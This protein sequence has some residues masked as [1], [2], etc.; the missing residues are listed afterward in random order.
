MK[1]FLARWKRENR[2]LH[3]RISDPDG[4]RNRHM[5]ALGK[6]DAGITRVNQLWET[7]GT[8]SDAFVIAEVETRTGKLQL[9]ATMDVYSRT[10]AA[11]LA[12]SESSEAFAQLLL[13]SIR[14]LG[15][16]EAIRHDNGPRS[17]R[18]GPRA[19]WRGWESRQSRRR[20]I[21]ATASRLSSAAS[22]L[23]CIHFSRICPAIRVHS[24]AEAARI[25]K[26]HSF[27]NRRGQNMARLYNVQLT[28]PELQ[29]LLDAWLAHVYGDRKHA[30]LGGRTPNEVF[31]EAEARG[32]VRRVSE[33][34]ALDLLLAEDGVAAVGKK[35]IRVAGAFFWDD[36]LADYES[37][38]VQY[39]RTRDAGRIIIYSADSA[40]KF[41]C[42]AVDP[43]AAGLDRQV[44]AIAARNRQNEAMRE[45]LDDLR[46]L[47]REHRPE[48]L[49]REIIDNA[50]AQIREESARAERA[51]ESARCA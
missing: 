13:K 26:R 36:A 41:I 9:L 35:G 11:H 18:R 7:D 46:R 29:N 2:S 50:A 23:S 21:A 4:W 14:R 19:R 51:N 48:K 37:Q 45:G 16:P 31:A 32:E 30:G 20:R 34:R 28:G 44:I 3:D 49:Y 39:V 12:P 6:M 38:N 8:K 10:P 42:V 22:E 1:T 17:C 33:E 25:R 27:A 47:K 40:P 5:I 24:P 43:D 15:V